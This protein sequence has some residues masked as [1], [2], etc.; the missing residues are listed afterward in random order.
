[1]LQLTLWGFA[2]EPPEGTVE[3]EYSPSRTLALRLQYSGGS[4][5]DNGFD[6]FGANL[7]QVITNPSNQDS[8][9]TIFTGT[10]RTVFLF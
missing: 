9:G 7:V 8:N 6:A 2:S 1:M 10:L 5:F 3:L 4:V